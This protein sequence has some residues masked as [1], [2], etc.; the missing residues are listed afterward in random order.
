MADLVGKEIHLRDSIKEY[1]GE[2]GKA[3]ATKLSV[4]LSKE[5][6]EV[7]EALRVLIKSKEIIAVGVSNGESEYGLSQAWTDNGKVV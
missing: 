1:L 6:A 5:R 3:S 2:T 7:T 4:E